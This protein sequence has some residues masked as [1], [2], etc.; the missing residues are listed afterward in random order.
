[1]EPVSGSTATTAQ[2]YRAF[3]EVEAPG[4]SALYEEWALGVAEDPT[5]IQLID[6][7]APPKR[8]AILVFA[9]ARAAGAPLV[10]YEKFRP[11]LVEHWWS[12][13]Q[14]A[15]SRSTQTNEPGR[16]AVLLPILA[17]LPQPIALLEVGASAGLCL[18]PDHYSYRYDGVE[19]DPGTG[20]S[21]VVLTPTLSGPVPI[22]RSMPEIVWRAG[23]D[24]NPLD[25]FDESDAT[26][27]E[28]LVW[29]EHTERLAR[30]RAALAVARVDPPRV[31]VGD[32]VDSLASVA[33]KA[34]AGATL[35]VFHSAVLAYLTPEHRERFVTE[36]K[37]LPGHWISNEGGQIVPGI[38]RPSGSNPSQL[39]LSLDGTPVAFAGGHGQSLEWI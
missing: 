29:P 1:M 34:P 39:V 25:V 20:V 16:C 21:S 3:A 10:E 9:S 4:Q 37:K 5:V 12:V 18:L 17:S 23:I 31:V 32:A 13:R 28:T 8:Q 36:V 27:L 26:W 24:L 11:W 22:P 35:V 33:A 15:E 30:L 2:R 14:V 38:T 7:L 6:E 19:L